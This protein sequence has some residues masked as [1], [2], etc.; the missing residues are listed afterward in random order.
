MSA[1]RSF[2]VVADLDIGMG[3]N[4]DRPPSG[5]DGTA[6]VTDDSGLDAESDSLS[7]GQQNQTSGPAQNP[8]KPV[9]SAFDRL[10]SMLG[11]ITARPNDVVES[12]VTET[13]TMPPDER[14]ARAASVL[15]ARLDDELGDFAALGGSTAIEGGAVTDLLGSELPQIAEAVAADSSDEHT[16]ER[17]VVLAALNAALVAT[18]KSATDSRQTA[19]VTLAVFCRLYRAAETASDGGSDSVDL[20]A[21]ATDTVRAY[22]VTAAAADRESSVP[23]PETPQEAIQTARR[24]GATEWYRRGDRTIAAGAEMA[25][26]SEPAFERLSAS[27]HD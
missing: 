15:E 6:G 23:A 16:V 12:L 22:R 13:L 2:L 1:G 24:I 8:F 21:L 27:L 25:G 5:A 20:A 7:N 18:E 3:K 9:G 26:V 11:M 19:S 14:F 4:D 17:A 10:E